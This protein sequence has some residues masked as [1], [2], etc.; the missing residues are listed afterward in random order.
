LSVAV[1]SRRAISS[2]S[3]LEHAGDARNA[4]DVERQGALAD[5]LHAA[6]AILLAES[7]QRVRLAH[8]GPGQRTA[9]E[10]LGV[11]ADVHAFVFAL[12][13]ER[14]DVAQ[15]VDRFACGVI[16]RVGRSTAGGF[17][18]M[19]LNELCAEVDL[20]LGLVGPDAHVLA[21]IA[22]G[23]RVERVDDLDVMI[24]MDLGLVEPYRHIER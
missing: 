19:H 7:E 16:A 24:R 20:H 1:L 13:H 21:Q 17:A 22:I 15:R 10:S 14:V 3:R 4:H 12:G 18:R 8:L 9:E 5:R 2:V 23:H 6:L 11:N